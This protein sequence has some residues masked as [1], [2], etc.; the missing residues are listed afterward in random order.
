MLK[1]AQRRS[2]I[3]MLQPSG[4]FHCEEIRS[5]FLVSFCLRRN[6][7]PHIYDIESKSRKKNYTKYHHNDIND[8]YAEH[9]KGAYHHYCND[10]SDDYDGVRYDAQN[11]SRRCKSLKRR[12]LF[13]KVID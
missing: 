11:L 5:V 2:E 4:R 1:S 3:R 10:R 13:L 8:I 6:H 9:M 12:Y 7:E